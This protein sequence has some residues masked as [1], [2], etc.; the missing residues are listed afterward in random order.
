MESQI[1]GYRADEIDDGK[2][3]MRGFSFV[4][5]TGDELSIMKDVT[6]EN[7]TGGVDADN[8]DRIR[9]WN[10]LLSGYTTYFYYVEDEDGYV[11]HEENWLDED[12]DEEVAKQ[13][14]GKIAPY[15]GFW[16]QTYLGKG[17]T[18]A[19]NKKM[20]VS[21]AVDQD[22]YDPFEIL[23]G[24]LQMF[25]NPYPVASNIK[26][27]TSII[28]ANP[29]GGVDADTADRIRI[30][31]PKLSGYTTYFYYVEDEDGYVWHEENWLDEDEDQEIAKQY[32][33]DIAAGQAF[34]Y[35]SYVAKGSLP[36]TDKTIQFVSPFE[37][38]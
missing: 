8:A 31:N 37:K 19:E 27:E 9:I 23:D 26:D 36:K 24:K 10:P 3:L 17:A 6:F 34:W 32:Q 11:W 5:I 21:G 25:V 29:T 14:Q 30:W 35:Q 20:T 13:Y 15:Q 4:N 1:V 38:K 2:L 16:Y 7:P 12:E 33:G 28:I 18:P 22:V